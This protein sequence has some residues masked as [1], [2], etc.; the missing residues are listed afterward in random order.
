MRQTSWTAAGGVALAMLA[1]GVR[2]QDAATAKDV[3][4]LV[5]SAVL[6]SSTKEK[7][8]G[9]AATMSALYFMGRLDGRDPELD[10]EGQVTD[11]ALTMT[12]ADIKDEAMRCG[13]ELQARGEAISAIGARMQSRGEARP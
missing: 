2:A 12:P 5:V 10:L 1:T 13:K 7:S 9:T 8:I 11:A 3:R 4:C 6:L